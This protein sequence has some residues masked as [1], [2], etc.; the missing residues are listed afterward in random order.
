MGHG[1]SGLLSLQD[2]L[3]GCA[4]QQ[5]S[6]NLA[7]HALFL[8]LPWFFFL[9][10]LPFIFVATLLHCK[11]MLSVGFFWATCSWTW[12]SN[13]KVLY[14]FY[15]FMIYLQTSGNHDWTRNESHTRLEVE[16]MVSLE[17]RSTTRLEV[18]AMVWLESRSGSD[19]HGSKWWIWYLINQPYRPS[20]G[21]TKK[22]K[23][24]KSNIHKCIAAYWPNY[25]WASL[26]GPNH[27]QKA[28][29]RCFSTF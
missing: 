27:L 14:L 4:Q 3:D 6:Q 19:G 20:S 28:L 26:I 8:H 25:N 15:L 24:K 29:F 23:R 21:S 2:T 16:A 12:Q 5:S 17:S 9:S 7:F 18:E 11:G 22:E 1:S 10:F 13:N